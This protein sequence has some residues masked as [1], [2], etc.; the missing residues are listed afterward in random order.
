MMMATNLFGAFFSLSM[1]VVF[2]RCNILWGIPDDI[3]VLADTVVHTMIGQWM[4]IPGSVLLS[5]CCPRG[6]EATM[7]ALVAGAI[8]LGDTVASFSGAYFLN[9]LEVAP[10]G[11]ESE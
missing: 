7:Y 11:S 4:W 8:D 2:K 9:L 1:V 3:F 6:I 10:R 5:Q